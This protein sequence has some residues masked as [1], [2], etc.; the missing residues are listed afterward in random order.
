MIPN[1]GAFDAGPLIA[2][3]QIDRLDWLNHLFARK[4]VPPEV[5]REVEPSL[6]ELPDWIEIQSFR[7]KLEYP[8]SLGTGER[9]AI[10]LAVD[11]AADFV[12]TDDRRARSV[13]KGYGI[14]PIG[15]LGLLVRLKRIGLT[16]EVRPLMDE[17]ILNGLF[18]SAKVY[19]EIL[20]LADEEPSNDRSNSPQ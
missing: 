17:V 19:Q 15:S 3:Y 7:A 4:L 14:A 20:V 9:A 16:A 8:N 1:T 12:V 6:G 13:A 5:A 18:V 2:F 11:L 10:A